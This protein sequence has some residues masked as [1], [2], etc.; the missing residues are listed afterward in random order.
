[1]DPIR[2]ILSWTAA[3]CG[4]LLLVALTVALCGLLGIFVV[5]RYRRSKPTA[6]KRDFDYVPPETIPGNSCNWY[7]KTVTTAPAP[8]PEGFSCACGGDLQVAKVE[9]TDTGTVT[10]YRCGRCGKEFIQ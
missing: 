9:A 7:S 2:D 1:M 8:E 10:T 5:S 4:A 6:E 3:V